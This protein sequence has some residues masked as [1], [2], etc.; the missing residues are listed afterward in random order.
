M[1]FTKKKNMC[2]N[3]LK[4]NNIYYNNDL[5]DAKMII[6]RPKEINDFTTYEEY[7]AYFVEG[8]IKNMKEICSDVNTNAIISDV[9]DEA[10]RK[11]GEKFIF[12][13]DEW[14]YIFNNEMYKKDDRDNFLRFLESLLKDKAYVELAYMTGILPIAKNSSGSSINMFDEYNHIRRKDIRYVLTYFIF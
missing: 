7:K 5:F 13:I 8:L 10:Y 11:I 3:Q 12:V 1:I 9:L 2:I 6:T 4:M 14:D